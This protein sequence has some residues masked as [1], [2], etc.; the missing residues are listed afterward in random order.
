MNDPKNPTVG[1]GTATT[2][3]RTLVEEG[4]RFKGS[5]T[6]TCPILVQGSIEG[7]IEGPSLTVSATG[8]VSGKIAAGAL[9]SDGK[10]SGDFDVDTAQ[11]AGSIENNTVVRASALDLKVTVPNGKLQ[12]TFGSAGRDGSRGRS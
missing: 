1:A 9:K 5:L 6:S 11:L 4:T 8:A 7:D 12:L 2:E 3:K 10:I